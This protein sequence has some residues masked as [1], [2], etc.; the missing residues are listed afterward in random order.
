L[1]TLFKEIIAVYAENHI[2][3]IDK[4]AMLLIVKEAGTNSY[5]LDLNG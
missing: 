4:N 2:K 1:L 3:P 5:H